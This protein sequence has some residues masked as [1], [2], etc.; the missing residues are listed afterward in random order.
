M[1]Y[2]GYEMYLCANGHLELGDSLSGYFGEEPQN[3]TVCKEPLVWCYSV[4]Q[5]NDG[6]VAPQLVEHKPEKVETCEC[7]GHTRVTEE[8][9]FCIPSNA[10]HR[11]GDD[12]ADE[13]PAEVPEVKVQFKNLDSG[14]L[15][16]TA[17]EAWINKGYHL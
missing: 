14:E 13:I 12:H 7:C 9:T 10:G 11:L 16:D 8:A 6:G 2:E 15:F 17:D 3:C 4:D 5:T 1:S